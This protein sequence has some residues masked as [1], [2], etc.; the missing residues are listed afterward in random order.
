MYLHL[1]QADVLFTLLT[2][3]DKTLIILKNILMYMY[4]NFFCI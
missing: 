2:T 4:I 1:A 3:D